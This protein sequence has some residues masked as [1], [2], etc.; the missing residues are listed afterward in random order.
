[1]KQWIAVAGEGKKAAGETK[2]FELKS[3]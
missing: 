2:G 1:M 3:I